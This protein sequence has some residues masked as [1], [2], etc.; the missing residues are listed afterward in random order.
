MHS[1]LFTSYPKRRRGISPTQFRLGYAL[2]RLDSLKGWG[3]PILA[4]N[5]FARGYD[6]GIESITAEDRLDW[7]RRGPMR[8]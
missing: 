3:D 7:E 4:N 8:A 1:H 2:G 6:A 5:D